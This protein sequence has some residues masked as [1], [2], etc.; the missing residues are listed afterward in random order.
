MGF[1]PQN[2]IRMDKTNVCDCFETIEE[3]IDEYA[4]KQISF[5]TKAAKLGMIKEK[6]KISDEDYVDFVENVL[7]VNNVLYSEK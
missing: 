3:L 7:Y 6:Y 2:K 1:P 4:E 5:K